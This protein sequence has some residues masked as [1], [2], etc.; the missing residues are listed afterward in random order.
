MAPE[1]YRHNNEH[2]SGRPSKR[3]SRVEW[4]VQVVDPVG[5][6]DDGTVPRVVRIAFRVKALPRF[7]RCFIR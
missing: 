3:A 5:A 2:Q 6:L 1:M 7:G 4:V